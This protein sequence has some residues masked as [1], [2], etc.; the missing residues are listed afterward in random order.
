[1]GVRQGAPAR[2]GSDSEQKL[3]VDVEIQSFEEGRVEQ[4]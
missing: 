1:M 3:S 2:D 4:E